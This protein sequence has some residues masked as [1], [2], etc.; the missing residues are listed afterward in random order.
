MR[1]EVPPGASYPEGWVIVWDSTR[2]I[3][4]RIRSAATLHVL[5][6]LPDH[7]SFTEWRKL[8]QIRLA[9]ELGIAQ[10]SVSKAMQELHDLALVERRG[11]GAHV[12]WRMSL[13]A[14]WRGNATSYNAAR[15]ARAT[16]DRHAA[17]ICRRSDIMETGGRP[18]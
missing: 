2:A 9:T 11:S 5:D 7:L 10:G 1:A 14:G 8:H 17:A 12:E 4:R 13:T 15:R 3:R 18:R 16:A 6:A